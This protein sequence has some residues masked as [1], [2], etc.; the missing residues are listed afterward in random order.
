MK[1]NSCLLGVVPSVFMVLSSAMFTSCGGGGSDDSTSTTEEVINEIEDDPTGTTASTTGTETTTGTTGADPANEATYIADI[2]VAINEVRANNG[3]LAPLTEDS[4]IAALCADHNVYMADVAPLNA[5]PVLI[6]HDNY[7]DRAQATFAL[8]YNS[9]GE[10]VGGIRYFDADEVVS[11]FV[12]GWVDS[13][14]HFEA[15]IG[16]YTH[17]GIDV[18]VD[19][20]DGTI[21][22]TQI[23][24]KQ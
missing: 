10:N 5:R 1:I 20:D 12:Q 21:Y 4:Q 22:A 15:I 3:G 13:T 7:E 16:D 17:T 23:F 9:F 19:T 6:S 14:S 2:L 24:A 18:Y 11:T 8:G